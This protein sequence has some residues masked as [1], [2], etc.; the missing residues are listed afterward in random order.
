MD[1]L[2]AAHSGTRYLVLLAG[3]I[4]ALWFVWGLGTNRPFSRPAPALFAVFVGLLDLQVLMGIVLLIGGHRPPGIW[5]HVVLMVLAVT[6][7]HAVKKSSR[8]STGF[9][10]PL[11][12][13]AGALAL[14]VVGI[15]AI[16]RTIL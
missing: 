1:A 10:R 4:A 14:I 6:F 11:L 5:G 12:G 2:F 7:A 16:G 8:R 3:L 9:G 15:L 13:V